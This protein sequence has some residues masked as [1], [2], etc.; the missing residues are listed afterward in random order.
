MLIP[1]RLSLKKRLNLDLIAINSQQVLFFYIGSNLF[2]H[3]LV[4]IHINANNFAGVFALW[5]HEIK[6]WLIQSSCGWFISL[7][8]GS[9]IVTTSILCII[10]FIICWLLRKPLGMWRCNSCLTWQWISSICE[11]NISIW[12]WYTYWWR[13]PNLL[14]S[15]PFPYFEYPLPLSYGAIWCC[16]PPLSML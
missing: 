16:R 3:V 8:M 7:M 10:T 12:N 5:W 13:L 15:S 11:Q 1:F 14:I 9:R 2:F 6:I 4:I